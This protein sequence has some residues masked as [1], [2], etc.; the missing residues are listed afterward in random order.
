MELFLIYS[1]LTLSSVQV[2][3]FHR[4]RH[5]IQR[6]TTTT[7]SSVPTGVH[8]SI[9]QKDSWNL[10]CFILRHHEKRHLSE[11]RGWQRSDMLEL[12]NNPQHELFLYTVL[13]LVTEEGTQDS[14]PSTSLI[15]ALES[16]RCRNVCTGRTPGLTKRT[17]STNMRP[18]SS[19]PIQPYVCLYS[20]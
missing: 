19:C 17:G 1:G 4:Q 3:T 16:Y 5:D 7:L 10:L 15:K 2:Y 20:F 11:S 8:P 18:P 6:Q 9:M 12:S 13:P 14:R